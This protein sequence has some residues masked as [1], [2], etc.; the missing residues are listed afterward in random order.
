MIREVTH[1]HLR[2][3]WYDSEPSDVPYC[4]NQFLGWVFFCRFLQQDGSSIFGYTKLTT[5]LRNFLILNNIR[6]LLMPVHLCTVTF[7]ALCTLT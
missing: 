3:I 7:L 2:Q 6:D 5:K 4:P 1:A